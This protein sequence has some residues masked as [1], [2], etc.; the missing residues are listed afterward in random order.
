[1]RKLFF[2]LI[3]L[4]ASA[5][6]LFAQQSYFELL[7]QDIATQKVA[8]IT[9]V[10]KFT[11]AEAEAIWPVYRE[12]DLEVSKTGDQ[13]IKLIKD[14]AA[15]FENLSNEKAIELMNKNFDLQEQELNLKRE[16]L[17]KFSEAIA[18][19]RATKLMQVINQIDLVLDLQLASQLPLIGEP[20]EPAP[21]PEGEPEGSSLEVK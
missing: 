4:S 20:I 13:L 12:Y 19:A 9:E 17:K 10:M 14:Y 1:M 21:E 2:I 16:Y 6:Q 5:T 3:L 11:D 15:N 18:P 8:L 7:R